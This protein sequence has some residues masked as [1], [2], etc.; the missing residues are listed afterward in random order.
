V[1]G[2]CDLTIR[3]C[4]PGNN[5]FVA[6]DG[7]RHW[8]RR[9]AWAG[10]LPPLL[11]PSWGSIG[12][13]LRPRALPGSREENRGWGNHRSLVRV[14]VLRRTTSLRCQPR[15][16]HN[17]P[18]RYP[19]IALP[20]TALRLEFFVGDSRRCLCVCA[21]EGGVGHVAAGVAPPCC[22]AQE[23]DSTGALILGSTASVR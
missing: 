5:E 7:F 9:T 2:V 23:E 15:P 14:R 19:Q 1:G 10:S 4:Q 13:H 16:R 11:P 21:E 12:G 22:C 6:G 8:F 20:S 17:L 3:I 18:V